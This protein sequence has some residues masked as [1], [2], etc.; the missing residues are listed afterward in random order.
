MNDDLK[1]IAKAIREQTLAR[2]IGNA[3]VMV[4]LGMIFLALL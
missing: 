3:G 4:M 1:D 2:S